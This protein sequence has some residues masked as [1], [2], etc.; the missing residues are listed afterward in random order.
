[1]TAHLQDLQRSF[2]RHLRAEGRSPATALHNLN[3]APWADPRGT[4]L[5]ARGLAQRLRQYEIHSTDVRV[6]DWHGKGYK[7]ADLWDAWAR[8]LPPDSRGDADSFP[9]ETRRGEEGS[10]GHLG[11]PPH[12]SA[13]SA[14]NGHRTCTVCGYPITLP[15]HTI[16]P[17]CEETLV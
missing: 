16:H 8:Y 2:L 1:M 17:T 10:E 9:Q 7:R 5:N 3:E 6:G 15:N 11:P 12:E 14:T 4:P 13:T